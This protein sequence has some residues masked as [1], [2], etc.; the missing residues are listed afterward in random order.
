V[1][2][3]HFKENAFDCSCTAGDLTSRQ[4]LVDTLEGKLLTVHIPLIR[5]MSALTVGD[6]APWFIRPS[7]ANLAA[8]EN[9][10]V[11]G[12]RVVLFF[13]GSS[14]SVPVSEILAGFLAAEAQFERCNV[15]FFGISI[16][17]NDV[18]LEQVKRGDRC[19]FLLDVQGELSI[20]YGV[21]QLNDQ[22]GGITYDP[23]TFVLDENLR[24]LQVIPLETHIPHVAQ[25]LGAIERLSRPQLPQVIKRQAPVLLIPDVFQPQFCQQLIDLYEADGGTESGFM[26]QENEKT[27]IALNP[28]VKRRRDL[29]ITD[30]TWLNQINQLIWRRVIPEVQKAFQFTI[31][32]YERYTVGCYEDRNQGFFQPHRDNTATG[33]AHRRF[34]MTINL[35][36]GMYEGGCL[37][38]PEYGSDLY[39]PD[40]GS[41]VIFSCSLLHEVT[42]VTQGRRFALLSFF[43]DDE[44][45]KLR[46]Q[47]VDQIVR[48]APVGNLKAG[49]SVKGDTAKGDRSSKS[50]KKPSSGF[51]PKRK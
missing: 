7:L 42:P 6:F 39:S 18:S 10:M 11:G 46:E 9:T 36:T 16:D 30:P 14:N 50:A 24:V 43:F 31:T 8:H 37:R 21:C 17:P 29:L 4:A 23:T 45:A 38:F 28:K 32:R 26:K 48:E 34:A 3:A 51:Q 49:G 35:N 1:G 33:S 22:S 41:A 27:M 12:Y 15:T 2:N 5:S 20:E 44:D 25:V 47:T 13:F 40:A 19:Q